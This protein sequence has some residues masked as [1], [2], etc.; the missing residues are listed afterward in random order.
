VIDI[1]GTRT[2]RVARKSYEAEDICSFV[3][4]DRNGGSLPQFS[5]GSH[6]LVHLDNG[7][8]R[9]YSICNDPDETGR[10]VLAVL[11]E[12][13]SR[14]GSASM[15]A[16]REGQLV[17]ISDPRNH[18]SL[19]EGASRH[20]FLAGGI[21]ITPLLSMAWRLSRLG[22]E[23]QLHSCYKTKTRAAFLDLMRRAPFAERVQVHFDDGAHDQ[24]LD[25]EHVL[26]HASSDTHLYVCGPQG[27]M[28]YV[29]AGA[30]AAGWEEA[31]LH[32][33]SFSAEF[34]A[35]ADDRLFEI[36]IA[37]SGKVLQVPV[38][39]SAVHVL[40]DNGIH[41]P[42]SCEMGVCGTCITRIL[43]GVP[44]HRDMYLTPDEQSAGD[45][46]TPCCS[47]AKSSRLVLDL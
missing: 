2:V 24:R 11:R 37:S 7:I 23:F 5:A 39:T 42:V 34:A 40:S 31:R 3:L 21:G 1:Q 16:L 12:P 14:G 28:D 26:R 6:I 13:A 10:Y 30:R 45:Q 20:L 47:R 29:L 41:L 18:F 25:L 32:W 36:E 17:Q 46:F 22:A 35:H 43:S 4:V 44:D 33:E 27:F 38:G 19:A 9:P 8:S 15:H